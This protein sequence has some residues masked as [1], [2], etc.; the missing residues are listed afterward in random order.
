MQELTLALGK[1]QKTEAA[2]YI[3]P[4]THTLSRGFFFFLPVFTSE[5]LTGAQQTSHISLL[6]LPERGPAAPAKPLP[7]RAASGAKARADSDA[8]NRP[9]KT[10]GL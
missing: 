10:L 1:F 8:T 4:P 7:P 2:L 6:P 9:V 3:H 5:L